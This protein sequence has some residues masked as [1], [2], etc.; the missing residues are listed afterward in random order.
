MQHFIV[1]KFFRFQRPFSL[2]CSH[3][4]IFIYN[5]HLKRLWSSLRHYY[6]F[7]HNFFLYL[8]AFYV[9]LFHP[10]SIKALFSG[11]VLGWEFS[12]TSEQ[13]NTNKALSFLNMRSKKQLFSRLLIL[14]QRTEPATMAK[15]LCF[16]SPSSWRIRTAEFMHLIHLCS[17]E[18]SRADF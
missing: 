3:S 11:F 1:Y 9:Y 13:N 5:S 7:K 4:P 10:F 16:A 17:L 2:V 18:S 6:Q 15:P 12:K 8:T 14:D